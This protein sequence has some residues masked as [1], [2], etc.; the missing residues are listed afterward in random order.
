[1]PRDLITFIGRLTPARVL[2]LGLFCAVII[3][4][5]T[6]LMRFGLDLQVTRDTGVIGN[7]TFGMRIHHG[8]AGILLLLLASV[9]RRPGQRK[10]VLIIAMGLI[11][12]DLLHHFLVLWPLT[13]SPQFDLYYPR[14]SV[15][16]VLPAEAELLEALL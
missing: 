16:A 2:L 4:A 9:F 3:E 14:P 12:S 11:F 15:A 1:M 8:Y 13:G 10:L 7:Y 5:V 6:A